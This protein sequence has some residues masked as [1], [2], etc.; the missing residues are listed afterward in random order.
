MGSQVL[1]KIVVVG[2]N[3]AGKSHLAARLH[4]ARPTVPLVHYDA[5]RLQTGWVKRPDTESN[6]ALAEAATK[7]TWIIEGGPSMLSLVAPYADAIIWLD[8]P[9]RVRFWRLLVRPWRHLGRTRPELPPGNVDWPLAQYRFAVRSLFDDTRFRRDIHS[10]LSL[11]A[12]P[13]V[14]HCRTDRDTDDAL[15]KWAEIRPDT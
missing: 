15:A 7:P 13:V 2:A 14:W 9:L 11:A 5:L 6:A 1:E 4:A 8:P 3:G 12:T 10:E